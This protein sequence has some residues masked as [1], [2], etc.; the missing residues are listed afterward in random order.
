M[1]A[2][3]SCSINLLKMFMCHAKYALSVMVMGSYLSCAMSARNHSQMMS[4]T[5]LKDTNLAILCTM[6]GVV[7]V[8]IVQ[9]AYVMDV[10][11]FPK[12]RIE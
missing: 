12:G 3:E 10:I 5:L 7:N 1:A 4:G 6:K 8:K 11:T 2:K 9:Q